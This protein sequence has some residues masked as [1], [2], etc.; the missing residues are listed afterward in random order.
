MLVW[1]MYNNGLQ[2]WA[3]LML[4]TNQRFG[5]YYSRLSPYI[6]GW[7]LEA[8]FNVGSGWRGRFGGANWLSGGGWAA[9]QWESF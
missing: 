2:V 7:I 5:K 6:V 9:I 4:S 8:I 1:N 3:V